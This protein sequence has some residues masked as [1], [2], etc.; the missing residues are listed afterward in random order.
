M[1]RVPGPVG[2]A[3]TRIY[4]AVAVRDVGW[5]LTRAQ[6]EAAADALKEQPDR[7]LMPVAA[8]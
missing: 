5:A 4:V 1:T 3:D 6:A 2:L 7:F 8:D